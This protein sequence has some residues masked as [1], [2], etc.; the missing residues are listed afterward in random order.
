MLKSINN[1]VVLEAYDSQGNPLP[2]QKQVIH[3][4]PA[5]EYFPDLDAIIVQAA[6]D[7]TKRGT[8]R[9]D[10]AWGSGVKLGKTLGL[11]SDFFAEKGT[12]RFEEDSYRMQRAYFSR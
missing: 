8:Y 1:T 7:E 10:Y 12:L 4:S 11:K 2:N 3:N 5:G 6:E 9:R